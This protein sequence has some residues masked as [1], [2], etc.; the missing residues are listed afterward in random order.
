MINPRLIFFHVILLKE[1]LWSIR[2]NSHPRVY[3]II[4]SRSD[5]RL[6]NDQGFQTPSNKRTAVMAVNYQYLPKISFWTFKLVLLVY[7]MIIS[8]LLLIRQMQNPGPDDILTLPTNSYEDE[9]VCV[10]QSSV[11]VV[12]L[13]SFVLIRELE[14]L[15]NT[16]HQSL[17]L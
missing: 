16:Q 12:G 8:D 17:D 14:H 9:E 4:K 7:R 3:A 10:H 13:A 15:K 11:E 6:F 5:S 2:L 1:K